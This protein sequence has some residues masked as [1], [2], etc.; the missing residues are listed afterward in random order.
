MSHVGALLMLTW[1]LYHNGRQIFWEEKQ[2]RRRRRRGLWNCSLRR[3]LVVQRAKKSMDCLVTVIGEIT[4]EHP[5]KVVLVDSSGIVINLK[6][7]GWDA[8]KK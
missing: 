2:L 4:S 1:Y 3:R 8:F 6:K 7:R 5:G